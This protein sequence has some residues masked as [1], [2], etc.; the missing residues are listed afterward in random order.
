MK[1]KLKILRVASFFSIGLLAIFALMQIYDSK[2]LDLENKWLI[3]A[4]IPILIG[5]FLSGVI[6]SFKGFGIELEANLSEKVDMELVGNVESYHTPKLTKQSMQF[7]FEMSNREKSKIERLQFE[8]GRK[9][10]YDAFVVSEYF[11]NLNKLRYV[12][13]IDKDGKFVC[14]IPAK[15]FTIEDNERNRQRKI[16]NIEKLIKGIENENITDSFKSFIT[17]SIQKD[18]SLLKAYKK[19]NISNQG[20]QINGDQILPVLD[21][22][23]RMVG[24]TRKFKLTNKIAEQVLK[25]EK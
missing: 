23:E 1:E 9:N 14:L 17:D 19:F 22:N 4:G 15:Q 6:K 8:Y 11:S 5:L 21:S 24:L 18:D 20:K 16:E 12:E 10:Y 7:L 25:S 2:I 3:V 13:I